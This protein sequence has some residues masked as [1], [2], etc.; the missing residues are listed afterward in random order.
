MPIPE[1]DMIGFC[2]ACNQ[3][4]R[5]KPGSPCNSPEKHLFQGDDCRGSNYTANNLG[6]IIEKPEDAILVARFIQED[7]IKKCLGFMGHM[8][9]TIAC[10]DGK[11][12]SAERYRLAKALAEYYL[13]TQQDK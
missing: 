1:L 11:R 3:K 5:I 6:F 13:E 10:G 12:C 8:G 2:S 7:D 9:H 4:V